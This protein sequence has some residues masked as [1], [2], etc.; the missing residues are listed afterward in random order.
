MTLRST[1]FFSIPHKIKPDEETLAREFLFGCLWSVGLN[2]WSRIRHRQ[3]ERRH[4]PLCSVTGGIN[5]SQQKKGLWTAWGR[6]HQFLTWSHTVSRTLLQ[7]LELQVQRS[8]MCRA[9][10]WNSE[11]LTPRK[12]ETSSLYCTQEH[13]KRGGEG[14][15]KEREQK[16]EDSLE[17]SPWGPC[18]PASSLTCDFQGNKNLSSPKQI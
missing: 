16:R 18:C 8:V 14:C 10:W 1:L 7:N 13:G 17:T 15:F 9:M 12:H 6:E 2:F 3:A 4:L 5:C 11:R